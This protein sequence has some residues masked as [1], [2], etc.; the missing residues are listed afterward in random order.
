MIRL[1][2]RVGA[3]V[4]LVGRPGAPPS[5]T[6]T[7]SLAAHRRR[8]RCAASRNAPAASSTSDN[9]SRRR[10][11]TSRPIH[12][13]A[14]RSYRSGSSRYSST[15]S[16]ASRS[17]TCCKSRAAASAIRAFPVARARRNRAYGWPSDVIEHMFAHRSRSRQE[18]EEA[19]NSCR[20]A[21]PRPQR[22]AP[23]RHRRL[24]LLGLAL[25]LVGLAAAVG[26]PTQSHGATPASAI[27]VTTLIPPTPVTTTGK[28]FLTKTF[29][30]NYT[31][32]I[33]KVAGDPAGVKQIDTDDVMRINITHVD[34][35]SSNYTHELQ[36]QLHE[37]DRRPDE[38][39]RPSPR[40]SSRKS[41]RSSS[42]SRTSAAGSTRW[43]N[44][45]HG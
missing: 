18:R 16:R 13:A 3:P 37:L 40:G 10:S 8:D 21:D 23:M 24:L 27:R 36:R 41:T 43:P 38:P 5:L 39:S 4:S 6:I 26:H 7:S 19:R 25:A 1:S 2:S 44:G 15:S 17:P 20:V 35:T 30:I 34:A 33:V 45:R 11:A 9:R 29:T 22:G 12:R 32:G 42:R 14:A 31:G 28:V